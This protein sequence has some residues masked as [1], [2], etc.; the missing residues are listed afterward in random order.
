[1][2]VSTYLYNHDLNCFTFTEKHAKK[3][4]KMLPELEIEVFTNAEAFTN[5]L[6]RTE[7]ALT[8][9]FRQEWLDLAPNLRWI[10]TPA[11][12]KDYFSITPPHGMIMTNGRFHGELMA[13]TVLA[14]MLGSCRGILDLARIGKDIPW[15]NREI[16]NAMR[17][18]RG[19]HLAILGFGRIGEWVARLAKP[20]GVRITGIKRSACQKPDYFDENDRIETIN[21]LERIL[22][23]VDHLVMVL[24][25]DEE[26]ND[27]INRERLALLPGHAYI[28]N[29]GR[30]NSIDESALA[31]ALKSGGIAGAC[32]DVF[33]EEPLGESSPLHECDNLLIMPHASAFSPNYMDLFVE[34]FVA[35]YREKLG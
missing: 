22:P 1:M 13:E 20:F 21:N 24:P 9:T 33:K 31:T 35:F 12:G 5:A 14:M 16:V 2:I 15:P 34:D 28:Y 29:I 23:E 8:W 18:L 4:K 26:T 6:G 27:L 30:G 11:A 17:P 25:S 7:I 19:S 32:L 3:L 10:A